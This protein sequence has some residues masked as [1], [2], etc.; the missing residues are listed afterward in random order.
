MNTGVIYFSQERLTAG[1]PVFAGAEEG[2]PLAGVD[3]VAPLLADPENKALPVEV[4]AD[5]IFAEGISDTEAAAFDWREHAQLSR[6]AQQDR[7]GGCWALA[8]AGCLSDRQAII[9]SS[10]NPEL[11]A[12]EVLECDRSCLPACGTCSPMNGFSYAHEYGLPSCGNK[13]GLLNLGQ[14]EQKLTCD[15]VKAE[16]QGQSRVYAGKDVRTAS[17]IQELKKEIAVHGPVSSVYRVYRDFIIGSDPRRKKLAFEETQGIYIHRDFK[18][19][20]YAPAD[21]DEKTLRSLGDLVGYHAVVI[22]GW[23]Q[24]EV[25]L[26]KKKKLIPYWIVRNSWGEKW[27]EKGYFKCAM[28]STLENQSIAMD[29]PLTVSKGEVVSKYGGVFFASVQIQHGSRRRRTSGG[30]RG[31]MLLLCLVGLISLGCLLFFISGP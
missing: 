1:L 7:C 21:A 16:A 30:N 18:P 31:I 26:D 9:S 28:T 23:N 13:P 10:S 25:E 27:G 19:S 29:L 20:L 12:V 6:V 4:L 11:S 8:V 14:R 24:A 5:S 3:F 17:S 22:V 2:P 15:S